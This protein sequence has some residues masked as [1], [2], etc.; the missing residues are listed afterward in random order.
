MN[1]TSKSKTL[2]AFRQSLIELSKF[3]HL[4]YDNVTDQI[5]KTRYAIAEMTGSPIDVDRQAEHL[6]AAKVK[7]GIQRELQVLYSRREKL[8]KEV[9]ELELKALE[10]QST[11]DEKNI[12]EKSELF[13]E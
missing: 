4:Q 13:Q 1:F 9:A 10:M 6:A 7:A 2:A 5:E 3:Q 11:A 12:V 8:Q